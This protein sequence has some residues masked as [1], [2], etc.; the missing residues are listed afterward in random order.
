MSATS[1]GQRQPLG[2]HRMDLV[3]IYHWLVAVDLKSLARV[4][5]VLRRA[6]DI[7]DGGRRLSAGQSRRIALARA[8]LS[9]APLV[10][11]DEPTAPLDVAA[12][13]AVEAAV[14][15]LAVGRSVLLIT[16]RSELAARGVELLALRDGAIAE[17][18][19]RPVAA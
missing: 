18:D 17:I 10:L 12:A 16:H 13:T 15:R 6:A 2:H 9:D 7:D 8:F 14:T 11:P 19:D 4:E 3:R 1:V 5:D